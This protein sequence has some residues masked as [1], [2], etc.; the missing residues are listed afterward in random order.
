MRDGEVNRDGLER[1][2][3]QCRAN[4]SQSEVGYAEVEE[5]LIALLAEQPVPEVQ[6]RP[7]VPKVGTGGAQKSKKSTTKGMKKLVDMRPPPKDD[8]DALF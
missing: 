3:E 2:L 4:K 5:R 1:A 8:F 7:E 6:A